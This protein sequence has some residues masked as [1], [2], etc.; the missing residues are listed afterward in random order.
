MLKNIIK[1]LKNKQ[2]KCVIILLI[3][4]T[5]CFFLFDL[6]GLL[7]HIF[8]SISNLFSNVDGET[9]QVIIK[10]DGYDVGDEGSI[11]VTKSADWIDNSNAELTIDI[12][13]LRDVNNIPKD[14][15]L[16][17]DTSDAMGGSM[18]N[19]F[20]TDIS[21]LLSL[22]LL[23]DNNRIAIIT[24]NSEAKTLLSLTN[25]KEE[26]LNAVEDLD[27]GGNRN[28]YLALKELETLLSSYQISDNRELIVLFTSSG[29]PNA[30]TPNQITQYEIINNKYPNATIYGIAY[31]PEQGVIDNLAKISEFQLTDDDTNN[32][33]LEPA[34]NPNY[35]ETFEIIEY[36]NNNYF[37]V[38]GIDDISASVG[39]VDLIEEDNHQK[40]IW[41]AN[42]NE[43][44]TGRNISLKI[45]LKLN[46]SLIGVEGLYSTSTN[47]KID[48]KLSNDGST[49]LESSETPILKNG[50]KVIY[51]ANLPNGCENTFYSE[52][53]FYPSDEVSILNKE[54][55]CK[56]Y[57]FQGWKIINDVEYLNDTIFKMPTNNVT[58][59]AKWSKLY[60]NKSMTG[61]V[62]GNSFIAATYSYTGDVQTFTAPY[63]GTYKIELWGAQ[64]GDVSGQTNH[65]QNKN[66]EPD[67]FLSYSGGHG[68]YSKANI[69]LKKGD[70]LY[71]V[72]G[73]KGTGN[74]IVEP[75]IG[76]YNGGGTSG[77]SLEDDWNYTSSGGG[78]THVAINTNRGE[79]KNYI[80]N[81]SEII[82]VAG[83]GGGAY[84]HIFGVKYCNTGGAGGGLIGINGTL[85]GY[86]GENSGAVVTI[87]TGGTQNEGGAGGYRGA[88]GGFGI[89]GSGSS[90]DTT[91]CG[92]SGGGGGW[93]GG[94]AAGHA[95]TGG[96]S[97]YVLPTIEGTTLDG[98]QS[99]PTYDGTSTMVGNTGN[100]YARITF[101]E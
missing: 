33:L 4:F 16:I 11:K 3:L 23:N 81:K 59:K 91:K 41:T 40:I 87:G 31:E 93:Y 18:L 69:N 100:G 2:T 32:A 7:G 9:K 77:V 96:G 66:S 67:V 50:Y 20:K 89:G 34:L 45:K 48:Y 15:V 8:T 90:C 83:G 98:T 49:M 35:Y 61:E 58:I 1:Q 44:R 60:L 22:V 86:V 73:G 99:I 21:D 76:G 14:I 37:Y 30:G 94:G 63:T 38:E 71:V 74:C 85:P 64:G 68:G 88:A 79:L 75:C 95:G 97:G 92:S 54:L 82:L 29:Y 51:D 84:F 101:V 5:L 24:Y 19:K 52:N 65:A 57:Q 39:T 47:I 10:S 78:A 53:I 46:N 27:I 56:G 13:S 62:Y 80:D 43:F 25:N 72:V 36:I 6:G 42:N 55:V 28:Y 12:S 26:L 70:I 17:L